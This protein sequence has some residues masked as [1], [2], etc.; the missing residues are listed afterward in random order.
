MNANNDRSP[1]PDNASDDLPPADHQEFS[2]PT[3]HF[4]P[5]SKGKNRF[6]VCISSAGLT[7]PDV[8]LFLPSLQRKLCSGCTSVFAANATSGSTV[9]NQ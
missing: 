1:T 4:Q 3:V 7:Q 9:K 8:F 6:D 2:K 5:D